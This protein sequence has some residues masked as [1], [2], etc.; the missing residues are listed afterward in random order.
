MSSPNPPNEWR[1]TRYY[2]LLELIRNAPEVDTEVDYPELTEDIYPSLLPDAEGIWGIETLG[3]V[4][5]PT[6]A[7]FESGSSSDS[8]QEV[9]FDLNPLE[10]IEDLFPPSIQFFR[11]DNNQFRNYLAD[12]SLL[13]VT[14]AANDG[15][16]ANANLDEQNR[17]ERGEERQEEGPRDQRRTVEPIY[18]PEAPLL[19]DR[20][21]GGDDERREPPLQDPP[22]A[23]FP[24]TLGA[25]GA[26]PK[27]PLIPQTREVGDGPGLGRRGA[28]GPRDTSTP[29]GLLTRR[30]RTR[31]Y[32]RESASMLA[33][34]S[35]IDKQR[36]RKERR[37]ADRLETMIKQRLRLDR[38]KEKIPPGHAAL[39]T[40]IRGTGVGAVPPPPLV[41]P[42]AT[43]RGDPTLIRNDIPFQGQQNQQPPGGGRGGGRDHGDYDGDEDDEDGSEG[44]QTPEGTD[45]GNQDNMSQT[46]NDR[47]MN[48]GL[49]RIIT[50]V[51]KPLM[52]VWDRAKRDDEQ[53]KERA[54]RHLNKVTHGNIQQALA[55]EPL[56]QDH[57]RRN[58]MVLM[59]LEKIMSDVE[60]LKIEA[61]GRNTT[62]YEK[63]REIQ[64]NPVYPPDET[65][66]PHYPAAVKAFSQAVDQVRASIGFTESP[67]DFLLEICGHSNAVASNY[68]LTQDQQRL[69]I[70]SVIP[71]THVLSKELAMLEDLRQVFKFANMQSSIVQ[72]RAEVEAKIESWKLDSSSTRGLSESLSELK[73]LIVESEQ[74]DYAR[75]DVQ[76]LFALMVKR[77]K[78][79]RLTA[80]ARR[81]LDEFLYELRSNSDQLE[82]LYHL[83]TIL[84]NSQPTQRPMQV[85]AISASTQEMPKLPYH[86]S[87]PVSDSQIQQVGDSRAAQPRRSRDNG[88]SNGNSHGNKGKAKKQQNRGRSGN[89]SD[90]R[91]RSQ[92]RARNRSQSRGRWGG[93][94]QRTRSRPR[95]KSVDPW[96][97]NKPYLSK[98]GNKLSQ[99]LDTHFDGFCYKCGLNNHQSED[100]KRYPEKV[101]ILTLCN[102][103]FS[104]FHNSC[105]HPLYKGQQS[106][107][108]NGL[109]APAVKFL[110][111]TKST[112]PTITYEDT[113]TEDDE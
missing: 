79:E 86:Y 101:T 69:L 34:G 88:N 19:T 60:N 27:Q 6:L 41:L 16:N 77:I 80:F 87:I 1:D 61:K 103:C 51:T 81:K 9:K 93:Q 23:R 57:D 20:A 66:S 62:Q 33:S 56:L 92:S 58:Q 107:D 4:N 15:E 59:A 68:G 46:S 111:Q 45:G 78:R 5:D 14:M 13:R 76:A 42:V 43:W 73:I 44:Y 36:I 102:K 72:T 105:K 108:G 11:A 28:L 29:A 83:Q 95:L 38:K 70:L 85:H 25:T 110:S 109:S 113:E 96:P 39:N 112:P 37:E 22:G 40:S 75:I 106:Q 32:V 53:Q 48:V 67:Y 84:R 17:N 24:R 30:P 2:E 31:A 8:E 90:N 104:G 94:R 99:E 47:D 82:L 21:V 97:A 50:H 52:N 35:F 49:S 12:L 55:M 71:S 26:R 10:N 54:M 7:V 98:N 63:L 89:R 65:L 64:I 74:M 18:N 91:P 100:C 3:T